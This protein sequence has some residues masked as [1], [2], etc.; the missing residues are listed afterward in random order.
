MGCHHNE[1]ADCVPKAEVEMMESTAN[2]YPLGTLRTLYSDTLHE[3]FCEIIAVKML[4]P[5]ISEHCFPKIRYKLWFYCTWAFWRYDKIY[6]LSDLNS[7]K[8]MITNETTPS[9]QVEIFSFSFRYVG[10]C[11]FSFF[12]LLAAEQCSIMWNRIGSVQSSGRILK[13]H[14][15][16]VWHVAYFEGGGEGNS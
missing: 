7:S 15:S 12:L 11:V 1:R 6:A 2:I 10:V 14:F 9:P 16:L 5:Q 4:R 3:A 8:Y 13:P